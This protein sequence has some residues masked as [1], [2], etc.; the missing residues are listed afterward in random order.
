MK[1][2]VRK[3]ILEAVGKIYDGEVNSLNYTVEIPK[4]SENGD[5]ATNIAFLLAKHL[6]KAPVRIAED[7]LENIDRSFF[8]HVE[9][10]GGGFINF[11][12]AY[13]E[14]YGFLE[15]ILDDEAN[16]V[17]KVNNPENVQ[18][19]FVSANPTGPLHIGHGRGAAF[20][21][22]LARILEAVG[23]NVHREYYINDAGN[24]MNKLGES[25]YARYMQIYD[26]NFAFPEDGYKGEYITKIALIL[27]KKYGDTLLKKDEAIAVTLCK[28][29]GKNYI[30]EEIRS[31]LADFGVIFDEWFPE[32]RLYDKGKVEET[33]QYLK[34]S[35]KIYELDSALWFKSTEFGDDKDRVLKKSD[36]ELTYFASDIAYHKDKL[37]RGFDKIIDVWGADH[38]GYVER[39]KGAIKALGAQENNL[40]IALV[41]MVSLVKSGEKMSMSTRAG[42]FVTLKWLIEEVGT[43]AA[44]FFYLMRDINSQ[45]EFDID[46]AKSKTSDNPVYYVQYAHAR[47][48]SLFAKLEEKNMDVKL[49]KDLDRLVLKDEIEIIKK[50]YDFGNVVN[51][52]AV[53]YQ[54][55]RIVYF[56]RELAGLFHT[57][58]YNHAIIVEDDL[59]LTNARMT[60]SQAVGIV[61]RFG[62]SLLGVKAVKRM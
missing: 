8:R 59:S 56:L 40:Y 38:H 57:Y 7:I 53:N 30:L 25:I 15:K 31:D 54:P 35:G 3:K 34:E 1:E 60:L 39:M 17:E 9:I 12:I 62:L 21:D 26:K 23:H 43:D 16:L 13:E 19:E 46:L 45:F 2:V 28:D 50:M 41:Q 48:C 6:K 10:A 22:S 4:K 47:V 55:H 61:V 29:E 44:R 52:A 18:V 33:L 11:F 51:Q 32:K 37:E 20:G 42:E 14:F 27:Q 5:F 58:Y 36:G 24:Q 49:C